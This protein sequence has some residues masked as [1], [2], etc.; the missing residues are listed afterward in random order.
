MVLIQTFDKIIA[1]V[2]KV[3]VILLFGC[4]IGVIVINILSRNLFQ[5]SFDILFE[6]TPV[7]V[8]WLSLLGASLAMRSERHIKLELILRFCPQWTKRWA[9]GM[10]SL[11][12]MVVMA[13][14]FVAST[15][16]FKEEL[17]FFGAKGWFS[18]ISPIFFASMTFRYLVRFLS[19]FTVNS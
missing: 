11:F 5:T 4:L 6:F 12:G 16:F 9:F 3:A 19:I 7:M 17:A 10:T 14:L 15:S 1:Q 18:I 13:I 2:E 8:L